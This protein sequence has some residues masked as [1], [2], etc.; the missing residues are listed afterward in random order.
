MCVMDAAVKG[1]AVSRFRREYPQMERAAC[2]HPALLGCTDVDWSQIPGCPA[3]IPV[4]LRSLL[5]EAAGPRLCPCWR[6]A[7]ST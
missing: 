6:T 1:A 2:D 7:S 4:L 3:G 5:D